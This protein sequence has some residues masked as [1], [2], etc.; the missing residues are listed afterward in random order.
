MGGGDLNMKKS[1]HPLLLK[2]QERVWLEE[3]KALEEKKKLDQLRKEKEEERQLQELQ[4]LQE[5]QT[6]KKRQDKLDWMYATPATGSGQNQNELEDYLLG[7]KRVDKILTADENEKIGAAH[8]NFIATQFANSA[9]DTAAK[10]REDPLLA[11]KQQEQAAYQALMSN[12]LR[13]RELQE[14]TGIKPKKEK[15][16]KKEKKHKDRK[17]KNRAARSPSPYDDRDRQRSASR[18]RY[19]RKRSPSPYSRRSRS[20]APTRSRYEDDRRDD[21]YSSRR[22]RSRDRTPD[23]ERDSR[24]RSAEEGKVMTWPRSDESDDNGYVPRRA[25]SRSPIARPDDYDNRKRRRTLSR[26]PRRSDPAP[27]KRTRTSPPPPRSSTRL[28]DASEDRAARLAAMSSN[29]ASLTNERRE[30]LTKLL[31]REKEE[32][33]AEERARAKSKGMGGFLSHEQKKVFGGAGGLEDRI[34]R[35][36]GQM[37][38]EAD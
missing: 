5:E 29:A 16:D 27:P 13:L 1:W 6:G 31:E 2:N 19:S 10:V 20:P 38:V 24:R 37:R 25:P 33:E 35:G 22:G 23:R 28:N 3:K 7:K 15:K 18:D 12:P 36:R 9:R 21:H 34:K 4:R 8:K 26:S 32:A 14:R 11:I 30:H 17:G